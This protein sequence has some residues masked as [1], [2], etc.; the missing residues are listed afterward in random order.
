MLGM[1]KI[2]HHIEDYMM[3]ECDDMIIDMMKKKLKIDVSRD[4]DQLKWIVSF[5][6]QIIN[7]S[8]IDIT[9]K[10]ER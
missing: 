6:G 9:P 3:H 4:G 2:R 5:S 10:D 8:I 7:E 1:D